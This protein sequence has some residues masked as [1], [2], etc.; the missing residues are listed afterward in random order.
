MTT[1]I[2]KIQRN[3]FSGAFVDITSIKFII[4]VCQLLDER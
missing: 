2:I 3:D 1:I 4:L